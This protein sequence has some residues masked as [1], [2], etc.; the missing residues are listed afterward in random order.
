MERSRHDAGALENLT[1]RVLFGQRVREL[2]KEKGYSQEGFAIACGLDRSYFGSV[3]RGERNISI[4]NIAAIAHTL[5]EPI[6]KLFFN[7]ETPM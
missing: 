6:Y 7:S 4:E 1:V 2:R 3:E 5:D